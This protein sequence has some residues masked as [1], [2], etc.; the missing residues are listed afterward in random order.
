MKLSQNLKHTLQIHTHK[1]KAHVNIEGNEQA[2][3]FRIQKTI[4]KNIPKCAQ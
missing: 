2:L 1:I 4:K 3:K